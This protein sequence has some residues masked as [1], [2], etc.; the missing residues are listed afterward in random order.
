MPNSTPLV[1][2]PAPE[3]AAAAEDASGGGTSYDEAA[4]MLCHYSNNAKRAPPRLELKVDAPLLRLI[5]FMRSAAAGTQVAV[6]RAEDE[7]LGEPAKKRMGRRRLGK[8]AVRLLQLG[9]HNIVRTDEVEI[10]AKFLYK[11]PKKIVCQIRAIRHVRD[12]FIKINILCSN[13]KTMEACF[14]DAR[15]DTLR[16]QVKSSSEQYRADP[17]PPGM[18]LPW[19]RIADVTEKTFFLQF[20]KGTLER[21]Y[22]KMLYTHPS[23]ILLPL[24]RASNEG[25]EQEAQATTAQ[26]T[27]MIRAAVPVPPSVEAVMTSTR[28]I[29]STYTGAN[30]AAHEHQGYLRFD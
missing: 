2:T 11:K 30:F 15:F 5:K 6:S 7:E 17:P 16:I 29:G 4:G 27:H 20:E 22:G 14:N 12:V 18:H 25:D 23:L 21:S 9:P 19:R 1:S 28:M 13:I 24:P 26:Q 8:V 3:H 10:F